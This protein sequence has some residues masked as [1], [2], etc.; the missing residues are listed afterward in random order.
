MIEFELTDERRLIRQTADAAT[1][2]RSCHQ[3]REQGDGHCSGGP[4]VQLEAA[5]GLRDGPR[6]AA[7]QRLDVRL[8]A[9]IGFRADAIV[10]RMEVTDT[11]AT[12]QRG[13]EL[14]NNED[15]DALVELLARDI[16]IERMGGAP[17]LVGRDAL[18]R[19]AEPDA[20]E[21]Q[22][23]EPMEFRE[24]GDR[25]FVRVRFRARGRGSSIEVEQP[26]YHVWTLRDGVFAHV[27]TTMDEAEALAAAGL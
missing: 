14:Y 20:F 9:A 7:V 1:R 13:Y 11:I 5:S 19:F 22:R 24:N 10:V 3:E 16:V 25:I 12:L 21:W 17:P 18:K 6:H 23:M 8:A 4:S 2:I 26:G 15:F 27:L